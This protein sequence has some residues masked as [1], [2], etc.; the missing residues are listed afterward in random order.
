VN[1]IVAIDENWAIGYKGDLLIRISGDLKYFKEKTLNQNVVMGQVTFES[2]PG[3]KPLKSRTNIVLT[4]DKN[5]Y[6]EGISIC[7]NIQQVLD[8]ALKSEKE[9]FII[10]GESV[11]KQF[12]PY[13]QKAYITKIFHKFEADKFIPDFVNTPDWAQ[14]EQSEVF[15]N[16]DGL[17]YQ[18]LLYKK[19]R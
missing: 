4:L 19:L 2:L 17:K 5:F 13:C 6:A 9:T 16:E 1:L 18:F 7:Y 3:K 10:G 12:I 8:L 11:Y 15:I 14:V